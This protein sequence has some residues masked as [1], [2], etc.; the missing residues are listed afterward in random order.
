MYDS[1]RGISTDLDDQMLRPDNNQAEAT[2]DRIDLTSTG[3]KLTNSDTDLNANGN[4]Y[5]Y[6][7]IRR[8]DGY[9]GKLPSA[10]NEVFDMDNPGDGTA[11][12]YE[13]TTL[14]TVDF[15]MMKVVTSTGDWF[16]P[17]RLIQG[18]RV[19]TNSSD[20][21]SSFAN[22]YNFDYEYGWS[23]FGSAGSY[24][25]WMWKRG[26]GMDVVCYEGNGS[27]GKQVIHSLSKTPEMIWI[28]NR[29]ETA[30]W[31][32]YHKDLNGGTNPERYYLRLNE[33][34]AEIDLPTDY[35]LASNIL[36]NDTAPTSTVVTLGSSGNLN[37][38]GFDHIMMLFASVNDADGNAI[39]KVSSYTGTGSSGLS[40]TTGFQPRFLLIKRRDA[41]NTNWLVFDSVRGFGAGNDS[42]LALNTNSAAVTNTN[43][44]EFTST[45]FTINET[46][47]EINNNGGSYI[48]YAHA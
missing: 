47:S 18:S 40:V 22:T 29:G 30:N 7:A 6:T 21:A 12:S 35:G 27:L 5:V 42:Q 15:A 20:T 11:P 3:F 36:F 41:S 28:K 33:D 19:K 37:K 26:Q 24:M 2:S 38:N 10:G 46:Y 1:K 17:A 34:H 43:F 23:D 45:G 9:V 31:I 16:T 13:S 25:S 32:V 4:R 48:Y 14:K 39:S 8:P 44:G